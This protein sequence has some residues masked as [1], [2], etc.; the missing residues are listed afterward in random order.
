MSTRIF[1]TTLIAALFAASGSAQADRHQDD[2][3]IVRARVVASVPVYDTVN[4]PRKE[5]W[6]ETTGYETQTIPQCRQPRRRH[7]RRYRG[8]PDRLDRRQGQRQGRRSRR[9]CGHWRSS[10]RPLEQRCGHRIAPD[11]G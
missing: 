6:I 5:C 3:M 11:S 7:R 2:E 8:R 10:G 9:R 4:E 1:N